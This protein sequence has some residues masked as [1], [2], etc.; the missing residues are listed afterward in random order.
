MLKQNCLRRFL[1]PERGVRGEWVNLTDSWLAAKHYQ[2]GDDIVQQ[3]LGQALAAVS[4]LSAT[5]KFE[6]SIILQT[7]S[8][9]PLRTL[10]AQAT[11]DHKIRGMVRCEPLIDTASFS[12]LFGTGRL[13]LTIEQQRGE[14]YQGIVPLEGESLA[15]ALETYFSQSEQLKTRL[16]LFAN[17]TQAVGFLLQQLPSHQESHQNDWEHLEILA[18]TVTE[19]ELMTLD[20][21]QLLHRLFHGEQV[22]IFDA[23]PVD[24]Q[25]SC[26]R[27]RI[28]RTLRAMGEQELQAIH[29]EHR[30]LEVGCEFC[31]ANYTFDIIDIETLL[32]SVENLINESNTRH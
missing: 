13:V 20:V 22:R 28:E 2:K 11:H 31:G 4:L 14:P 18:S 32:L 12:E 7:Q 19:R 23:E 29:R 3:Q 16:W 26:S 21:E 25:C 15:T 1:L 8:N 17:Q 27:A 24:F 10:V 30:N 9:G 6:G 5:I